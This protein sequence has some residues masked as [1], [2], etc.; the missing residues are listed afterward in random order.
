MG[1]VSYG[2]SQ[3]QLVRGKTDAGAIYTR[4][5]SNPKRREENDETHIQVKH[6]NCFCI[7][8]TSNHKLGTSIAVADQ[9]GLGELCQLDL[10]G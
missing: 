4:S 3:P 7:L 8:Y 9:D 5:R 1:D 10:M 6:P 2:D